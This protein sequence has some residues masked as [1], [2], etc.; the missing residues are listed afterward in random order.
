LTGA[1][2]ELLAS[3]V[4]PDLR[5][6]GASRSKLAA[7]VHAHFRGTCA[8]CGFRAS[9][10]FRAYPIAKGRFTLLCEFCYCLMDLRHAGSAARGC[11]VFIP[12]MSQAT[13]NGIVHATWVQMQWGDNR[14][15]AHARERLLALTMRRSFMD[16]YIGPGTEDPGVLAATLESL[17]AELYARRGE[18]LGAV[19]YLPDFDRNQGKIAAWSDQAY[20]PLQKREVWRQLASQYFGA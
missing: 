17:P 13:L 11:L 6:W 1:K 5:I 20:K 7:Q 15:R 14:E 2:I 12:E 8:G 10:G 18:L 19:R 9:V 3:V 16:H 4:P